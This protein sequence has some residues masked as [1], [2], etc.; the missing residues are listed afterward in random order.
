MKQKTLEFNQKIKGNKPWRTNP[1]HANA[2]QTPI[3][4]RKLSRQ[5]DNEYITNLVLGLKHKNQEITISTASFIPF[6]RQTD[7]L[8]LRTQVYQVKHKNLQAILKIL[9]SKNYF[10]STKFS[11]PPVSVGTFQEET[12]ENPNFRENALQITTN[13]LKNCSSSFFLNH[14]N[15]TFTSNQ[16]QVQKTT[17]ISI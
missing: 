5:R 16:I 10:Y 17:S 12:P 3:A 15:I 11:N 9:L 4:A 2:K 6:N 1:D 13:L 14:R 7:A 8:E